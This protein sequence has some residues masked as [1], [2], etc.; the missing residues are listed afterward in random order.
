MTT[1]V[2]V[3]WRRTATDDLT[4]RYARIAAR[5]DPDTAFACTSSIEARR[6]DLAPYP[7]RGTPTRRHRT[8]RPHAELSG[9]DGYCLSG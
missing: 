2:R 9:A 1:K 6:A 3:V 4:R 7:H 8:G 5:A